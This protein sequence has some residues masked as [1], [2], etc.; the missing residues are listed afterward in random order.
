MPARMGRNRCVVYFGYLGDEVTDDSVVRERLSFMERQLK[1]LAT[2][3]AASPHAITGLVPYVAPRR[4][5]AEVHEVIARHGFA[6]DPASIAADRRNRFEYPGLLAMRTLA[7]QSAPD[8]LL[9]YCH[10]KGIVQLSHGKMGLFRLHTHVGLTADLTPLIRDPDL[11]RAGL[12]PSKWGWCWYN[13]FWIKAGHM[14]RLSVEEAEDRYLFEA[15][16]GNRDDKEGYRGVLPLIGEVPADERGVPVQPWYRPAETAS[17]ALDASYA[18]YAA[19][20]SPP[21]K[22]AQAPES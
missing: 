12:F 8:D 3:I 17:P 15:L 10:S 11:N 16:I 1:W 2:L 14:A 7:R 6:I 9:Y 18:R 4:W 21:V 22:I 20:E 19:M 5:D 13:F